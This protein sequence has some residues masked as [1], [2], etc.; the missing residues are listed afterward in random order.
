MRNCIGKRNYRYYFLMLT[1][2]S[3]FGLCVCGAAI[4]HIVMV[5]AS[6]T[7][8]FDGPAIGRYVAGLPAAG[9]VRR[10]DAA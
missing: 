9:R 2:G 8:P 3:L 1:L 7:E 4:A 6:A 5:S 10:S